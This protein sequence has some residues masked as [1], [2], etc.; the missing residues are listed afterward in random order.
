MDVSNFQ[1]LQKPQQFV[2][3]CSLHLLNLESVS[4][5]RTVP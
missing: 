1:P 2:N 4:N 3:R 5:F